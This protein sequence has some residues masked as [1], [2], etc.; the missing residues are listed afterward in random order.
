[1]ESISTQGSVG[2]GGLYVGAAGEIAIAT[3]IGD[4]LFFTFKRA[5]SAEVQ[6]YQQGKL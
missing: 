3:E 4:G 5:G 2:H 1:M 6:L